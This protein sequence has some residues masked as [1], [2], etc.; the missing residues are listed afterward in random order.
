MA[1]TDG[2]TPPDAPAKLRARAGRGVPDRAFG[3]DPRRRVPDGQG[4]SHPRQAFQTPYGEI[5][6]SPRK[7]NLIAF[8]EVKA[9]ARLR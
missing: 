8:I 4:L 9:R 7:R 5:D 6:S 3:R 1:K 2:A